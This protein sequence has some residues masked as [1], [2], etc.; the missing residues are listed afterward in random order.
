MRIRR[1]LKQSRRRAWI[2][3]GLFTVVLAAPAFAHSGWASGLQN[4]PGAGDEAAVTDDWQAGFL[5][6]AEQADQGEQADE[7]DADAQDE[8]ADE[9][10][11]ASEDDQ[12]EQADEADADSQD[13]DGDDD[14]GQ[15]AESEDD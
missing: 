5:D 1:Y 9:D 6:I 4:D 3:G 11:S 7:A 2:L 13:E 8:D 12:G 15:S 10:V 14:N